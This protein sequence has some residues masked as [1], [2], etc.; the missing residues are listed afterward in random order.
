MPHAL[1]KF[2]ADAVLQACYVTFM[3][4]QTAARLAFGFAAGLLALAAVGLTGVVDAAEPAQPQ[5]TRLELA[6]PIACQP[7]RNCWPVNFVDLDSGP[8]ARDYA[9]GAHSY[10]G[11]KGTD[12]AI[13]DMAVMAQGVPVLAA[14][15]GTVRGVRDGMEDVPAGQAKPGS[16]ANRECGNG[17]VLVHP[18]GWETQYCHLRK[19]SLRVARGD[20]VMV[21]QRLGL[22]GHSGRAD[23][24]HVHL[25]VRRRGRVVDPFV[26]LD[27]KSECG[28]GPTPL[29][30]KSALKA[31]S[32][33]PTAIYAAGFAA[34]VP[35]AQTVRRGLYG[36]KALSGKA[37]MLMFWADIFW[38]EKGDQ[39]KMTITGP[40]GEIVAEHANEIPKRQA[41][42]LIYM[43]RKRKGLFWPRGTYT[44]TAE[45]IRAAEAGGGRPATATAS[46]EIK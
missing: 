24:P 29:W 23:F 4:M 18:D 30:S 9:C 11:H 14:A 15:P 44:G 25:S 31:L 28:L 16:L 43:G 2:L 6:L 37:P 41:R 22:V 7:G 17:V 5:P 42:R 40:D 10:N 26:G 32:V 33:S 39:V 13:R 8:G 46:I 27:R 36:D 12:I 3:C 21:G 38:V 1:A 20:R 35:K 45:L 19:G 34:A